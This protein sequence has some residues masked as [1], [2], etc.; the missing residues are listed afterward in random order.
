MALL[1]GCKLRGNMGLGKA[2]ARNVLYYVICI[3]TSKWDLSRIVEEVWNRCEE[4][5]GL[6]P[7]HNLW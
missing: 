6:V 7:Y 5:I 2:C 3:I 1:G 4:A